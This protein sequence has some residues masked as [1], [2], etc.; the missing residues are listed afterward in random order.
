MS[1][2]PEK[3]YW[4]G[5][6]EREESPEFQAIREEEFAVPP[7]QELETF[8]ADLESSVS[9]R[10]FLKAA[11]FSLAGTTLAACSR[12]P[13]EQVIPLLEGSEQGIPGKAYW[14]ASTCHGCSAGCGT[15]V[16]KRD[17]RPIKI[18]GNPEHP[19]SRGGLC[20]VGQASVLGL[21][22]S[23]R[24][25]QPLASGRAISWEELDETLRRRLEALHSGVYLLTSSLTSPS[26]RELAQRFLIPFP[27]SGQVEYDAFSYSAILDAHQR[28]HGRRLLPH[29]RFDRA[30]VIVS[31]DADFLGTWVSP[32]EFTRDYTQ[33]RRPEEGEKGFSHHIQ[34]EGRMSLTGTNAD[35]RIPA[36]PHEVAAWLLGLAEEL[37]R[38]SG[39][40]VPGLEGTRRAPFDGGLVRELAERLWEKRGESLLVC[41]TNDLG[42]QTLVNFSN[43]LLGNYGKTLL[44]DRPSL[45]WR[46]SDREVMDLVDKM[47]RG[48]V[49]ALLVAGANPAYSLP[50]SLDF[51]QA[52]KNVPLTVTIS[53]HLDET[54]ALT[55]Y[56]C[57]LQHPLESW[58]DSE[59]VAGLLSLSQ[60]MLAPFG[61]CR[62]LGECLAAWMGEPRDGLESLKD[63]WQREV[64]SRQTAVASL[65]EF[66]NRS[67]HDGFARVESPDQVAAECRSQEPITLTGSD[68]PSEDEFD[69]VLYEKVSLRDGQ[70]AHNPW[71]QELPDPVTKAVWDNYL[72]VAPA[73]AQRLNVKE[74]DRVRVTAEG[75]GLEVP[76]Q[77]QPG[78]HEQ[79]V[80]LAVGYGR[81]GTE[82][83]FGIGPRWLQGK[84]TVAEGEKVGQNT[85][86]LASPQG[87][88]IAFR[89]RVTL[90]PTGERSPLALTQTHHTI[91]VPEELGGSQRHM[92]REASLADFLEDPAAGNLFDHAELQLWD[93]DHVYTGHH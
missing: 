80:A 16:K 46:G 50:A 11:G 36:S 7:P 4:K 26:L 90:A 34:L 3:T 19:L 18:E 8:P 47:H 35:R 45:Q 89:N 86:P 67:V 43:H 39:V 21:Y 65:Q 83:F 84:P 75:L 76:V 37:A 44:I 41:G 5:I 73:V 25:S 53:Q 52:L 71:L 81:K 57:P 17:G 32:V 38:R 1:M 10:G 56:V 91:T 15:L 49:E 28:T 2:K 68:A 24:L 70:H 54:A 30:R 61:E 92:V 63:Y 42:L 33:G 23:H 14:Y 88:Q 77:I 78:Q 9:R 82:R 85:Y 62:S 93:D 48:E 22:D 58:S 55:E 74:G 66:W 13:A 69:L 64:F 27:E 6:D 40:A 31:F 60:P 87:D 72:S 20:A 29:Y 59:P 51:A 79:V 12:S